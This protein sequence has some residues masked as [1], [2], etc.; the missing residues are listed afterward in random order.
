VGG[1]C[2][3]GGVLVGTT[4]TIIVRPLSPTAL[5]FSSP[6]SPSIFPLIVRSLRRRRQARRIVQTDS[7]IDRSAG[8]VRRITIRSGRRKTRANKYRRKLS[9]YS[10]TTSCRKDPGPCIVIVVLVNHD[11]V[12]ACSGRPI[13]S[14]FSSSRFFEML[15]VVIRRRS[16]SRTYTYTSSWCCPW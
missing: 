16:S 14:S 11:A 3:H 12:A 4:T 13:L 7:P 15:V 1:P 9:L 8:L 6:P 5:L 10:T 2:C